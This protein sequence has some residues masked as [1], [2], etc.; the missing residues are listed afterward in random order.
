MLIFGVQGYRLLVS[1]AKTFVFG[2]LSECRFEP[3]CSVYA[4]DAIREHG[5]LRGSWLAMK[6]I[7]RCHPWGSCGHDPVPKRP[8]QA[9]QRNSREAD[10]GH[11][12]ENGHRAASVV[13]H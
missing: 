10:A 1:P 6:R 3:S 9:L 12:I 4:L 13:T 5:A 11:L 2:R 8:R 7:C